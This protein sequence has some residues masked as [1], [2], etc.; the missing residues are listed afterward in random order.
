MQAQL[1]LGKDQSP[2]DLYDLVSLLEGKGLDHARRMI[3]DYYE[4]EY[5]QKLGYFPKSEGGTE[6][7]VHSS[8]MRFAVPKA[9]L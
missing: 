7:K 5:G 6:D 3:S 8:V 2:M 1:L 9:E 4:R